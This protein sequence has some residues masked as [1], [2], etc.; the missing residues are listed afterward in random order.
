MFVYILT[1]MCR[2]VLGITA[3]VCSLF[4]LF[5][6]NFRSQVCDLSP[7]S[8]SLS[9]SLFL[10]STIAVIDNRMNME[11]IPSF[12]MH[13]SMCAQHAHASSYKELQNILAWLPR[14]EH[15]WYMCTC[16]YKP[17]TFVLPLAKTR[18]GFMSVCILKVHLISWTNSSQNSFLW[19]FDIM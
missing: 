8:P 18:H 14:H 1:Y 9:L 5:Q 7:L 16:E 4:M 11:W 10:L 2:E 15:V 19:H 17:G 12:A 3:F 13:L 6:T